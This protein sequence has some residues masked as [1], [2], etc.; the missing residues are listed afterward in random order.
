[1]GGPDA[2][3]SLEPAEFK[4]MVKAVR[5][6]EK[7]LGKVTYQLSEKVKKNKIF[8]RSLFAVEDI[9]AGETFTE[10]NTRSIRPGDG[11][12]PK[13]LKEITGKK[14]TGFIMRGTPLSWDLI[15]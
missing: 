5:D 8:A 6:V 14:A 2:E 4:E 11:L 15:E 9:P 10:Q 13:Y 12:P 7:A 3:F 1:M